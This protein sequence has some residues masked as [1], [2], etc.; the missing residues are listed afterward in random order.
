[1]ELKIGPNENTP[2]IIYPESEDCKKGELPNEGNIAIPGFDISLRVPVPDDVRVKLD[3]VHKDLD[4]YLVGCI[5]YSD[6]TRKHK[7]R[8][9]VL[10][11]YDS[12]KAGFTIVDSGN[13]AY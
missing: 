7:Y 6:S 13:N 5:D 10:E 4:L 8:T 1:L 11:T 12:L 3:R 2:N 9:N